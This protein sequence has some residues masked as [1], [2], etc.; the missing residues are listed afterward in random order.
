[1]VAGSPCMSAVSYPRSR[2]R[3]RPL[4]L[5]D[6]VPTSPPRN[7]IRAKHNY[8]VEPSGALPVESGC[9][10][11][12]TC[13]WRGRHG[14]PPALRRHSACS[15]IYEIHA[16]LLPGSRCHTVLLRPKR[17]RLPTMSTIELVDPELRDALVL[18]PQ[19]SLTAETL[20]RRRTD[21]LAL[22]S[23]VPTPD[24]PDIA[25]ARSTSRV[26]LARNP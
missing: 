11:H 12:R 18:W 1:M 6:T 8:H 20:T 21:A 3:T 16:D 26:H 13:C 23:S 22:L 14:W 4:L 15:S 10:Q 19:G 2:P 24:L 7:P 9:T 25:R 5:R 17:T